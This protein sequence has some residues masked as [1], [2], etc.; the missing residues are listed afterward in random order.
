VGDAGADFVEIV[1]KLR[2]Y[3]VL[4]ARAA[5]EAHHRESFTADHSGFHLVSFGEGI[6]IARSPFKTQL[7]IP[8]MAVKRFAHTSANPIDI[9][10]AMAVF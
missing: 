4:D 7:F 9:V 10:A 3:V 1:P 2:N 5:L 8:P 6:A